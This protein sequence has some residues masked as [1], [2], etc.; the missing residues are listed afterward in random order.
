MSAVHREWLADLADHP[1]YRVTQPPVRPAARQLGDRVLKTSTGV[2]IGLGYVKPPRRDSGAFQGPY[3]PPLRPWLPWALVVALLAML[4]LSWA[5]FASGPSE[6][7]V[8]QLVHQQVQAVA[9]ES[10]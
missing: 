7:E 2:Q 10:K 8:A 1:A 3:Y 4:G 5:V 6:S 9:Q